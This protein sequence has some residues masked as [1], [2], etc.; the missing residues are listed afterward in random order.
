MLCFNK[1][2][3]DVKKLLNIM[4]TSLSSFY[5]MVVCHGFVIPV[6]IVNVF[7]E[8]KTEM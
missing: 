1:G 8:M 2:L 5:V 6:D 7:E 3:V 4:H